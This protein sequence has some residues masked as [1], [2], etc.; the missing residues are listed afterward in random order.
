MGAKRD[1]AF[2]SISLVLYLAELGSDIW[3]LQHYHTGGDTYWFAF[4]LVVV[5][6]PSLMFNMLSV[7]IYKDMED[8]SSLQLTVRIIVAILQLSTPLRYGKL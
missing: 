1:I 7:A 2:T 5:L 6:F 8:L 4:T 3:L